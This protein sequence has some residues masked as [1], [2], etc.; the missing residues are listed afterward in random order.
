[1]KRDP[2][3]WLQMMLIAFVTNGLGP[4]GLKVL[5][6]RGLASWQWQYLIY[7]YAGGLVFALIALLRNWPGLY[8]RE[9]ALGA[10]M[11]LCSLGGQ[12][13]TGLALARE[14]PGHIVF[15]ITTG[16]SLFVVAAAGIIA[17]RERVGIYGVAGIV[18]GIIS[19]VMLSI[20]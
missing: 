17:F 1:M 6:E 10:A 14:V 2:R 3:F 19:L 9:V 18:L 16:G 15:P 8:S 12:S 13:F 7:W 4:F 5:N 11:G 20:P